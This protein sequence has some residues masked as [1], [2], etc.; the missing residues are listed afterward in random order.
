M[1]GRRLSAADEARVRAAFAKIPRG[2]RGFAYAE[3]AA[4]LHVSGNTIQR[5][6][7]RWAGRVPEGEIS[8][9]Y[10]SHASVA[11]KADVA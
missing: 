1:P 9:T 5:T 10:Y 6:V 7:Q 8:A 11:D 4:R 2:K 3:W